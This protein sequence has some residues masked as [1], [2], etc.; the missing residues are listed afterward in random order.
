MIDWLE[1]GEAGNLPPDTAAL[2]IHGINPWGAAHYRRYNEDNIDLARNFLDFSAIKP[3]HTAYDNLHEAISSP[4]RKA[5]TV[6]L[7]TLVQE[8]GERE[9]IDA[10]MSGQYVHRQGFG[11]GGT[12]P[13]WSHRLLIELITRHAASANSVSIIEYHSGLG[14]FGNGMPVT[15]QSGEGLARLREEFGADLQTPRLSEG[16]HAS[17]GHTT[18]GYVRALKG[19]R[20]TSIVLEFGTYPASQSLPVLLD[21]HWFTHHGE[22]AGPVGRKIRARNLEMHCP[23]NPEWEESILVRSREVIAAMLGLLQK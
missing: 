8:V 23:D 9:A 1:S 22:P 10:L 18:D 12:E 11:F 21:D 15:M 2:L 17:P 14:P 5:I 4:D 19:K 20:L 13:C 6:R 7:A 3:S 16:M